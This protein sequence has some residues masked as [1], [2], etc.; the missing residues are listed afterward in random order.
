MLARAWYKLLYSDG[1]ERTS[2]WGFIMD[3]VKKKRKVQADL[4]RKSKVT[5]QFSIDDPLCM[6][7]SAESEPLKQWDG[8][9]SQMLEGFEAN[10]GHSLLPK[11]PI[12]TEV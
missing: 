3:V 8:E 9:E 2:M 7:D 12:Y 11:K 1:D 6:Q 10:N 4:E 5:N